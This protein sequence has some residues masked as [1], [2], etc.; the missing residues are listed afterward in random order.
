MLKVGVIRFGEWNLSPDKEVEV[1][2]SLRRLF[3]LASLICLS[4]GLSGCVFTKLVTVPMRVTGAVISILPGVGNI[5]NDAIDEVADKI[6]DV[7][8]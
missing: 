5:A 7:P 3:L 1:L 6:D 8:I 2:M 4:M